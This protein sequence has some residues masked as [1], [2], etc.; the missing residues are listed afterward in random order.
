MAKDCKDKE[1]FT[2]LISTEPMVPV[3][4]FYK[5]IK[6]AMFYK[7]YIQGYKDGLKQKEI[8]K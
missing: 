3:E 5:A 6:E 7:G 4:E 1:I 2:E 8:L